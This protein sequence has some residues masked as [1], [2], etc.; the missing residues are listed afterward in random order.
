MCG[1][2]THFAAGMVVTLCSRTDHAS[3]DDADDEDDDGDDDGGV[4]AAV[5]GSLEGCA[6]WP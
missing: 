4:V 1:T 5:E 6:C 3:F 2:R